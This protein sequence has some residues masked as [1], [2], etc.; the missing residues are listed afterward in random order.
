MKYG[1]MICLVAAAV[2]VLTGASVWEGA[3]AVSSG[4][5]LPEGGYY[6]AT[7][8]FPR[9]TVVDLTNL[10]NGASIRVIVA[11]GL[12][13][14]GLLAVISRNAAEV[15]GLRDRS[16]GRIRMTQPS[17]PVAFS[18]FTEGM[19][20]YGEPDYIAGLP[21]TE[22]SPYRSPRPGQTNPA[23]TAAPS[24][25]DTAKPVWSTEAE[26]NSSPG[27]SAYVL[28][29]E[30]EEFTFGG[31]VDLP[32]SG[33][34]GRE[35]PAPITEIMPEYPPAAETRP[36][37]PPPA[38]TSP[39]Y[40]TYPAAEAEKYDY[41]LIPAEERPPTYPSG[42]FIDP[43]Y[44]IPSR[45][46]HSVETPDYSSS[47]PFPLIGALEPGKYYVQL[48]AFSRVELIETAVNRVHESYPLAIHNAGSEEK[49]VYRVL[50]GPMNLGESGA[51]LQ[52]LKSIG[53]KDAFVRPPY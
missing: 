30:W 34:T 21:I 53:Y 49:P 42:D 38:E 44:T 40:P 51:T 41:T 18:R 13:T 45:T 4:G 33:E 50:L 2:L 37:Y 3:A 46:G 27:A 35:T 20:T 36:E 26:D 47:F 9:N 19:S 6:A 15:I 1:M 7:N 39:Q 24:L 23:N 10:E 11:A 14:P 43:A 16:I 5:D 48:G 12:E 28:E 32:G 17:D 29:P 25:N 22:E 8:S 31:V 52:R